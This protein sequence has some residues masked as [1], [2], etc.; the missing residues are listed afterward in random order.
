MLEIEESLPQLE[1]AAEGREITRLYWRSCPEGVL[2]CVPLWVNSSLVTV[3]EIESF[4]L[5]NR[6][7]TIRLSDI[8]SLHPVHAYGEFIEWALLRNAQVIPSAYPQA[9]SF[10]QLLTSLLGSS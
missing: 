4:I 6:I 3:C 9:D 8:E 1:N 7:V 2:D 10:H 5:Y